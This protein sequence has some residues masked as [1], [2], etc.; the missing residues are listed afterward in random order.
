MSKK[1]F[2]LLSILL[3]MSLMLVACGGNNTEPTAPSRH[4]RRRTVDVV[5]DQRKWKK[6]RSRRKCP[7]SLT[8]QLAGWSSS[9]AENSRLQQ[10][11]DDFNASRS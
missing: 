3:V 7:A 1:W 9:D 2:M 10:M 4:G 11:V 8:L 5:P 6:W